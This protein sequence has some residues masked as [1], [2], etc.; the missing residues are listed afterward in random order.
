[1]L[2]AGRARVADEVE[3][4][5]VDLVGVGPDDCVRAARDDDG[6]G[7]LQQRGKP[8]AGG[9]VGQDAILVAVDNQDGNADRGEIAEVVAFLASPKASYVTGAIFAAD[10]GR[11]AI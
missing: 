3:H 9:L 7:I 11:T 4:C 1:M 10:G 5:P 6:A 2:C 8:A